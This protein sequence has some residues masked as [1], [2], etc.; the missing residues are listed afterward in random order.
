LMV[1]TMLE[2]HVLATLPLWVVSVIFHPLLPVAITSLLISLGVCIVA[3]AQA[4]L[5]R[6]KRRWWSRP[7]VGMLFF[8]Q[9]IVRGWARYQGR[10]MQRPTAL[11]ARQTLDSIALRDSQQPL[12]EVQYWAE[13]RLDRLALVADILRRLD[14]QGWPNKSDI[15]WS[16]YDVEVYDTRWSKLQLTTV[17]EEHPRTKQLIRCRL[18]ARW[19]LRARVVFWSLCGFELLVCGFVGPRLPWLW[20]LLLTLPLFVWFLRR[21]QR[22]LRSMIAVLL[23]ELAKEWCLT[24]V[25]PQSARQPEPEPPA[26][27]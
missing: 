22:N 10:L 26:A 11:A 24:K 1:T 4:A 5:P 27:P 19:A 13:Q 7:L 6:N 2:Y 3:G 16:D 15:G 25:Q 17:A 18:R 9:P 14:Q 21:E 12:R 23:D 8:L 20:L